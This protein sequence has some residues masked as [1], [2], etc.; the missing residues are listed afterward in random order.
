MGFTVNRN[1]GGTKDAEFEAYARLLRQQGVD[2]GKLPR[3]PEPGTGR[4][5]L[6]VWDTEEKAQAFATE[7]KKRTRDDAW[8]VVEVAAPPSEGPMGPII[9]QVGRRAN[10]LVF[11]LHPLSRAMIQSAFP[12]AKGAAATISINFET[13]RDFQATHGSIDALA[14]ELVPTLT[15]LKPQELE[16]LGYALIEDDTERTL[17]FVRPG[18]LVQA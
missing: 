3:A 10:G 17:V 11:G 14:R 5:W 4:R 1:D 16:K 2:L 15:G 9:V 6:Y 13:F 12:A 7:L 8:V 18:D